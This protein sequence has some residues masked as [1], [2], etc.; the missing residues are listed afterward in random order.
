[1]PFNL[2]PPAN[3]TADLSKGIQ[4]AERVFS[5]N[6]TLPEIAVFAHEAVERFEHRRRINPVTEE[7]QRLASV[8]R[9]A[10][11]SAFEACT[12]SSNHAG[13]ECGVTAPDEVYF[14]AP[15]ASLEA[16]RRGVEAARAVF[17]AAGISPQAAAMGDWEQ[18]VREIRGHVGPDLS[19]EAC[20]GAEMFYD[21]EHAAREAAGNIPGSYMRIEGCD[22]PE[23]RQY[24]ERS[25]VLNWDQE[26]DAASSASLISS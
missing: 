3:V 19:A 22:A 21:A 5:A 11:S 12:G 10:A 23:W 20:R 4:A 7:E 24:A 9:L 17:R 25:A 8:Y 6:G 13:W 15:G 16:H 2:C 14:W 26:A 18:Q 1:M